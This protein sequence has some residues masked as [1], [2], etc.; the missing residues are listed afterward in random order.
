M[1]CYSTA[2]HRQVGFPFASVQH[3]HGKNPGTS[4]PQL[5]QPVVGSDPGPQLTASAGEGDA[6]NPAPA[7]M[8]AATAILQS[9]NDRANH[10]PG[11]RD[12]MR[13]PPNKGIVGGASDRQVGRRRL[14]LS[15]TSGP[16]A[17]LNG[18]Q[19][20]HFIHPPG[21]R[22]SPRSDHAFGIRASSRRS[23]RGGR[24]CVAGRST[25]PGTRRTQFAGQAPRV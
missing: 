8:N 20:F 17:I 10:R 19:S 1:T 25:T 2:H 7:T 11:G 12:L 22:F 18:L 9:S 24:V 21:P 3:P 23:G 15:S 13:F 4:Q 16:E 5:V 14:G 6:K